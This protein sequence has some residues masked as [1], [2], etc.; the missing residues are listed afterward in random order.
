MKK[1]LNVEILF[2]DRLDVYEALIT[3]GSLTDAE[4]RKKFVLM[5]KIMETVEIKVLFQKNKKILLK[6]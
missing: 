3:I 5:I 6:L 2:K 1:E 4:V